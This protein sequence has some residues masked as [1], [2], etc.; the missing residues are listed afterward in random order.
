[1][2]YTLT[3]NPAIDRI[4]YLEEKLLKKKTNRIKTVAFDLGGKGL[5]GSHVLRTLG[6]E[7]RALGFVGELNEE[8]FI[9]LVEAKKLNYQFVSLPNQATREA[10]VL[11]EEG[12]SGSR[13]LTEAGVAV[14]QA[15]NDQLLALVDQQVNPED[16]VLIAGSLP[17]NYTL[18]H[19]SELLEMLKNKGC[20]IGCDL[21]GTA[22]NV[23]VEA[24]VDFVK[25][26]EFELAELTHTA[27]G[28]DVLKQIKNIAK[29]VA[30]VVASQGARG[31]LCAHGGK[32]YR[33][34][35]PIVKEVNDTGAGDCFVG[36]F[37]G[38][39]AQHTPLIENLMFASACAAS[40]VQ[41]RDS[42]TFSYQEAL[43]L[44]AQVSV[45][46]IN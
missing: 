38:G 31:S 46:E 26:N 28:K 42:T 17:P 45:L 3:L 36:A 34:V 1:M 13:M 43:D 6:I 29:K 32:V 18:T 14:N 37:V 16:M 24:E 9:S 11:I 30:Y 35:P 10:Y 23:A 21:S 5:H 12:V 7:N 19:L 25:P 8:R 15:A 20:F 4:L 33:I 2:I 41:Y 27:V 40:K 22:L 44:K 39:I